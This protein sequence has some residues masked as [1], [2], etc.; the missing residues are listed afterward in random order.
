MGYEQNPL[1]VYYCYDVIGD[2]DGRE[3][4]DGEEERKELKMCIAEVP[5]TPTMN[6]LLS[7]AFLLLMMV[8][9]ISGNKYT[10]GGESDVRI[11]TWFG[12]GR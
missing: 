8:M 6:F 4:E 11:P 10:M 3:R 12:F 9:M 7:V 2:G 5:G 1:S